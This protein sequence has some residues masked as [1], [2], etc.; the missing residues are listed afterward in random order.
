LDADQDW[1]WIVLGSL[2]LRIAIWRLQREKRKSSERYFQRINKFFDQ[3]RGSA[4]T[5][6]QAAERRDLIREHLYADAAIDGQISKLL[7]DDL[8]E[9]AQG[10]RLPTP[11]FTYPDG[12][13]AW[14]KPLGVDFYHLKD[15]A[16]AEL[17]SAIRRERKERR[18]SWQSW[19]ALAIGTIGALIGLVSA[20]KK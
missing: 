5:E 11:T 1:G 16:Y 9:E 19:A 15:A 12:G 13:D 7:T 17:R 4:E 20:L 10:L 2:R 8:I 6:E 18:E 3:E 14:E